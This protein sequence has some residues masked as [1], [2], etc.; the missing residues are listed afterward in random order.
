MSK[1]WP[2]VTRT[3]KS[4]WRGLSGAAFG[5]AFGNTLRATF[6]G[7]LQAELAGWEDLDGS[8]L[9]GQISWTEPIYFGATMNHK[10]MRQIGLAL[11]SPTKDA[12]RAISALLG[13]H[14]YGCEQNIA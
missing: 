3:E 1:E 12:I 7:T 8:E 11:T 2:S 4:D 10:H 5:T 13:G 6:Q 14:I 9:G